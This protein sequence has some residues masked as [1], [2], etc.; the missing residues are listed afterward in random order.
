[1]LTTGAYMRYINLGSSHVPQEPH[2][3]TVEVDGMECPDTSAVSPTDSHCW[4]WTAFPSRAV[5]PLPVEMIC[6]LVPATSAEL[7][8]QVDVEGIIESVWSLL[9]TLDGTC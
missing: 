2:E 5:T 9:N 3:Q 7:V 8:K 1:M 4:N 6:P